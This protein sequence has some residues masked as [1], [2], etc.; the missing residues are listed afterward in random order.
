MLQFRM[1]SMLISLGMS[2]FAALP[3]TTNYKL[4]SYG[5]GSGGTANSTTTTYSIEGITGELNGNPSSTANDASNPGFIQTQQAN[6]PK[7]AV[8]TNSGTYYNKV[9]FVLDQQ[10]NPSDATYLISVSTD[11]FVS[12]IQY[13]QS[14]GT[15]SSTLNAADY[16]TYAARGGSSGSFAIGL[17]GSSP[18]STVTYYFK[19]LAT[20]G[21]KTQSAYGPTASVVMPLPTLSFNLVTSN[22]P[23]GPFS[24]SFGSLTPGGSVSTAPQTINTTFSTDAASGGNVDITGTNGGL[25][26]SSTSY[27][28]A[29]VSNDLS[30][31]NEGY[32]VTTSSANISSTSGG[33]YSV[34]APY[35]NGGTL[36]GIV[37]NTTR[38]LYAASAP[39]TGGVAKLTLEA[40]AGT[41]AIA[42]SDYQ[43][44]L[45]FTA[46]GNF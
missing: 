25:L 31:V 41:T 19:A 15:L 38:P 6:V 1:A 22:Q 29:S 4:N 7:I 18:S 26:S 5:F 14:D 40:R 24:I 43:D 3:A 20:Q 12:N 23:S 34:V 13:L 42:A 35:N 44:V 9:H 10:G 32:G 11:N 39:V 28:I 46:A 30:A 21:N 8:D 45:T 33:P 2:F 16:E 27:K 37:S 17:N 36:V